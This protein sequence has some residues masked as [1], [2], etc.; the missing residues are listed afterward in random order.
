MELSIRAILLGIGLALVL[1]AANAYLGLKVGMTVSASIPAAVMSFAV[2]RWFRHANIL[3]NNLIQTAA[4]AGESLAAGM[5]FTLPA[6]ILLGSWQAFDYLEG[7]LLITLGGVLGVLMA[8]PLRKALLDHH[9]LT[10]PEGLAT[11]QVL[12]A[13]YSQPGAIHALLGASLIAA[14]VKLLQSGFGIAGSSISYAFQ[15]SK[16][17]VGFGADLSPVLIAVGFIVRLRIA[18]L[19]LIGGVLIW[20]I[21]MPVYSSLY[22]IESS[23]AAMD[24]AFALW[25]AKLRFIGVGAMLVAG[26]W[27]LLL[28]LKPVWRSIHISLIQVEIGTGVQTP[29]EFSMKQTFIWIMLLAIPIAVLQYRMIPYPELVVFGLL[30]ALLASFLFSTVAA[31]MAGLVGSSNNPISGVTIATIFIAALFIYFILGGQS[32]FAA[33]QGLQLQAAG[34]TIIIGAVVCCAAAIA[35]DT[36]QDLKAGQIVGA[37]PRYQTWMQLLGVIAAGLILIPVL[38]LLYEAYGFLGYMPRADMDSTQA[39]AAPQASLMKSVALGVFSESLEWGLIIIG[40]MVAVLFIVIDLFLKRIMSRV[41]I[42]VMA[43]AVGMYLPITLSTPIFIGGLVAYFL[44]NASSDKQQQGTLFASGLI[45]GEALIGILL[46]IPFAIVQDTRYFYIVED[47]K[48]GW[49]TLLGVAVIGYVCYM[50]YRT[51]VRELNGDP[52][53]N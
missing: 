8:V 6:L 38:T 20:L 34:L 13:G 52:G 48:Q 46:A 50:L 9:E 10:F 35:G 36:M 3:E 41:R 44:R 49:I 30:F 18:G 2:L 16:W 17:L 24:A 51:G 4:S 33:Q 23:A 28:A 25:S 31:Y 26:L 1:G 21:A 43:V 45:A 7:T 27:V 29:P 11:A 42:P 12:K 5:I 53:R 47:T 39:L 19:M 37:T 32:E 40:M 15:H 22:P 14:L